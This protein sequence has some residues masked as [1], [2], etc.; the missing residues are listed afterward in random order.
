MQFTDDTCIL[1]I[2]S[3]FLLPFGFVSLPSEVVEGV[4]KSVMERFAWVFSLE[5]VG[6]KTSVVE[7][8]AF[9]PPQVLYASVESR[10]PFTCLT[11]IS[12]LAD[13]LFVRVETRQP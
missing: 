6:I 9:T 13:L 4:G 1:G 12:C 10:A 2:N 11:T 8:G 3:Y 7:G 5:D